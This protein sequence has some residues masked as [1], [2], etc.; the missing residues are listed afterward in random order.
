M[1]ELAPDTVLQNRYRILKKIN[2]GG[3]GI[4]YKAHDDV[5]SCYVTVKNNYLQGDKD[6]ESMSLEFKEE[7]SNAFKSEARLLANIRH[8]MIPR[9]IDYFEEDGTHY[10]VMDFIEGDDLLQQ[11]EKRGRRPFNIEDVA[12]WA[13]NLLEILEKLHSNDPPIIHRDIKP[14]NIKISP[15]NTV[16]LLDFGLA[17]G[18]AGTMSYVTT[19]WITGASQW[20]PPEQVIDDETNKIEIDCQSDLYALAATLWTLLTGKLP[21][22]ANNRERAQLKNEKDPLELASKFNSHV[23]TAV[24]EILNKAMEIEKKNRFKSANEMRFA[25]K[26]AFDIPRV[27]AEEKHKLEA[28]EKLR[29]IIEKE[30]RDILWNENERVRET[31]RRELSEAK[32]YYEE[33]IEKMGLIVNPALEEVKKWKYKAE[34]AISENDELKKVYVTEI[35]TLKFE[36][37]K[38]KK[39]INTSTD[40]SKGIYFE[41]QKDIEE[42]GEN[43]PLVRK[44][45][46][47]ASERWN[48]QQ[49]KVRTPTIELYSESQNNDVESGNYKTDLVNIVTEPPSIDNEVKEEQLSWKEKAKT[50]FVKPEIYKPLEPSQTP[51]DAKNIKRHF[52]RNLVLITTIAL[53]MIFSGFVI[54]KVIGVIKLARSNK[55]QQQNNNFKTL[56]EKPPDGMVKIRGGSFKMGYNKGQQDEQPEHTE[57]V[58]SF[59]IDRTEV[60]QQQYGQFIIANGHPPPVDWQDGKMPVGNENYPITGITWNDAVK[61][62]ES[63]GKRLPNEK[64]WEF[65]ARCGEKNFLYPWGNEWKEGFANV[66]NTV[67]LPVNELQKEEPCFGIFGMIGNASEWTNSNYNSSGYSGGKE[68]ANLKVVRGGSCCIAPYQPRA[69][70][71]DYYQLNKSTQE[72]GF[73]CVKEVQ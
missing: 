41:L 5:L 49:L 56:A 62:C 8:P 60:T 46:A 66:Q 26:A 31:A 63:Q 15:Q 50:W 61:Y 14:D 58:D 57:T 36:C 11:L 27:A 28:E 53:V 4:V 39:T 16:V 37:E 67:L 52:V 55:A 45:L 6:D 48:E 9:V 13:D 54:Y 22:R 44:L 69:T 73:R 19:T 32:K 40:D 34:Q 64:E 7:L 3:V 24:S 43:H 42:Q 2:K 51:S 17:K 71:R 21:P 72:I 47:D 30:L 18:S 70:F 35:E 25:L 10:L 1:P 29:Q 23:S 20:S 33:K 59:Y 12:I 38:L 68:D 65:A